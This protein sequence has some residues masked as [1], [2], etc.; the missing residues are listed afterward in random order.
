MDVFISFSLGSQEI[1]VVY[2]SKVCVVGTMAIEHCPSPRSSRTGLWEPS[3]P[4]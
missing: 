1:K 3:S 4:R 2:E